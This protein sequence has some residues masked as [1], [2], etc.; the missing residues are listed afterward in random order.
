MCER[1]DVVLA[2]GVPRKVGSGVWLALVVVVVVVATPYRQVESPQNKVS[3][4]HVTQTERT[5]DFE[6]AGEVGVGQRESG[7]GWYGVR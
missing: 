6:R 4:Y 2:R 3:F 7:V 1:D 5:P